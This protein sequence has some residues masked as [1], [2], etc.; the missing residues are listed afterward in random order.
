MSPRDRGILNGMK[1]LLAVAVLVAVALFLLRSGHKTDGPDEKLV[2]DRVW[3]DHIPRNDRDIVNVFAVLEDQHIG[4]FQ[5]ASQWKQM[6]ELFQASDKGGGT[7]GLTY[8][9][10]REREV[11]TVHAGPC[12]KADFDYCLEIRGASRGVKEYGSKKG[13]EIDGKADLAR[14]K[15]PQR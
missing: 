13:W 11:V 1:K 8:P 5:A 14:L 15:M 6:L 12:K 7:L 3:I 10:T 4:I 9:Q 2:F